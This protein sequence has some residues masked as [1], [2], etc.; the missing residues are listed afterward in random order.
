MQNIKSIQR[1]IVETLTTYFNLY[2]R[3]CAIVAPT[4]LIEAEDMAN[5]LIIDDDVVFATIMMQWLKDK[6]H[7][8]ESAFDGCRGTQAFWAGSFD[9]VICDMVMPEQDGIETIRRIRASRSNVGIVAIS[10]GL[11]SPGKSK[12]DI[13]RIATH[14][15]ADA[16]LL[17]PFTLERL[18]AAIDTAL[19]ARTRCHACVERHANSAPAAD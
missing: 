19:A 9:I 4:A 2:Q 15:G 10:G 3:R 12:C 17:K 11:S 13:L 5:I 16:T 6:G 14:L 1:F 8:V 7:S 18:C